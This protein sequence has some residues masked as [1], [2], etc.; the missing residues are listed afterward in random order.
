M[1]RTSGPDV[2][3]GSSNSVTDTSLPPRE[4]QRV[5]NWLLS[6][7]LLGTSRTMARVKSCAA[8]LDQR[9]CRGEDTAKACSADG[10]DHL[11][12]G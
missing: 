4:M 10:F 2:I 7:K 3:I 9:L 12:A 6:L 8:G 11:D 5:M 1:S